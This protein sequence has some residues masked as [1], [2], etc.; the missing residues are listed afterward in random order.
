MTD[1]LNKILQTDCTT[2]DVLDLLPQRPPFVMID[3]L[4]AFTADTVT[5]RLEVRADCIFCNGGHML[6][7]GLVENMAQTCAARIGYINYISHRPVKIGYIG[8]VR[9]LSVYRTPY[10]DEVLCTTVR[11]KEDV[12]GMTLVD[13]RVEVGSELLAEAEMKIA[14][15]DA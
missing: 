10:V 7:A 4:T 8:A 11:V 3:R 12:F 1:E 15:A 5:T 9:G 14:L 6:A 13:A 2:A